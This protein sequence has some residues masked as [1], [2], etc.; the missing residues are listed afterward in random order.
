MIAAGDP[1]TGRLENLGVRKP[2]FP[3][4]KSFI[5]DLLFLH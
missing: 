2:T 4:S 5:D 1:L 3:T